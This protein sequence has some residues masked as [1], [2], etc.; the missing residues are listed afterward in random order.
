[1]DHLEWLAHVCGDDQELAEIRDAI[2]TWLANHYPG[3][4]EAQ[5]LAMTRATFE[6]AITDMRRAIPEIVEGMLE[7]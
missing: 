4:T 6:E 1:M 7:R 3:L 5:R 2:E